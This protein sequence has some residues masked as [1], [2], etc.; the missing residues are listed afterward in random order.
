MPKTAPGTRRWEVY[1]PPAQAEA[2]EQLLYSEVLGRIPK[3]AINA[4]FVARVGDF[5]ARK[6]LVL[7]AYE[8]FDSAEWVDGPPETVAKLR[9]L[10]APIR[11]PDADLLE[12]AFPELFQ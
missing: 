4:F 11:K 9:K 7:G 3:G 5:F 12:Q 1:L 8:G 6:R 2:L 10:L